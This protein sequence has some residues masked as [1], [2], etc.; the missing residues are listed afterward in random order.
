ML[1][2]FTIFD[3]KTGV[4]IQPFCML[5]EGSAKRAFITSLNDNSTDMGKYPADFTLL[6][7][8]E[9]D[10]TLGKVSLYPSHIDCGNGL[11]LQPLGVS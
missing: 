8:G 4:Y 10:E 9:F 5:T 3:S 1:K 6:G 11:H 2:M 7:I